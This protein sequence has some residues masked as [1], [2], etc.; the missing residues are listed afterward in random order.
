MSIY[1]F[2]DPD[3]YLRTKTKKYD[4]HKIHGNSFTLTHAR[5][6]ENPFG[7]I[8]RIYEFMMHATSLAPHRCI[9]FY[10][11]TSKSNDE[12]F[13]FRFFLLLWRF[14]FDRNIPDGIKNILDSRFSYVKSPHLEILNYIRCD[15]NLCC[16]HRMLHAKKTTLITFYFA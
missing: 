2:S 14:G 1:L 13:F 10:D 16:A 6:G 7:I 9:I 3:I 4:S 5:K 8:K 12:S 15:R 11:R